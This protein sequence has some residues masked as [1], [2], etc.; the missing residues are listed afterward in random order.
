MNKRKLLL[1]TFIY[2]AFITCV[3]LILNKSGFTL[4]DLSPETVLKLAHNNIMLVCII[5]L[6]IMTLQNLFTFIPLILVITINLAL[7][8][9][10]KGYLYSAL[11]STVGST[12]IFLSIRYIFPDLF[13][14]SK[15]KKYEQKVEKNGF[16]FVLTGRIFP[17]LPTNLINIVSGLSSM[18]L[19]HFIFGTAI[20]NLIYGFVLASASLGVLAISNHNHTMFFI[21]IVIVII[22]IFIRLLKKRK[23]RIKLQDLSE[24]EKVT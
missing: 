4:S 2:I 20:G 15:L 9:F 21:M 1:R 8:G 22:Y 16:L 24:M 10:W 6:V 23:K 17:F 13:T 14:S 18:K 3:L 19:S 7:F 5:M 12:A 11:C